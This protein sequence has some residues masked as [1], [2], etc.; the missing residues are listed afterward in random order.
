MNFHKFSASILHC[1]RQLVQLSVKFWTGLPLFNSCQ[2]TLYLSSPRRPNRTWCLPDLLKVY[3]QLLRY[4]RGLQICA[5]SFTYKEMKEWRTIRRQRDKLYVF[6]W[7]IPR[8][9]N[10]ICRRFGTLC[11]FHLHRQVG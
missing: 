8:R 10:F 9:L 2:W 11:L 1:V 6:F 7:V 3:R 4:S 5:F